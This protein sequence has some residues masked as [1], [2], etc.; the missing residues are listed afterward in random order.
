[1]EG[2]KLS[3][4]ERIRT[5][6]DKENYKNLRILQ[7]DT[8][9]YAEMIERKKKKKSSCAERESFLKPISAINISSEG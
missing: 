4:Q 7:V 6:G 5:L 2:I 8:I 1:M 9:K 3:N